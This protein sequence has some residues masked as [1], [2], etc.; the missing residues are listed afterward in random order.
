ML[1]GGEWD[2]DRPPLPWGGFSSLGGGGAGAAGL[3]RTQPPAE[4]FCLP[5]PGPRSGRA[6]REPL[7]S[8]RCW[9]YL[10]A[11][12]GLG[13]NLAT[14]N[15]P[16]GRVLGTRCT[17]RR[18]KK[19]AKGRRGAGRA[20]ARHLLPTRAPLPRVPLSPSLPKR[21]GSSFP[22]R[23]PPSPAGGCGCRIPTIRAHPRGSRC[24]MG[25][26]SSHVH[27]GGGEAP[28]SGL[29]EHGGL[30]FGPPQPHLWLG[31]TLPPRVPGVLGRAPAH[32]LQHAA[33]VSGVSGQGCP[34]ARQRGQGLRWELKA[35]WGDKG[36][37]RSCSALSDPS[38]HYL[39][40]TG[41]LAG[42]GVG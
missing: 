20:A 34:R 21:S 15:T 31:Q 28:G 29:C 12:L 36:L 25:A 8:P 26:L 42:H 40:R 35:Q 33:G 37:M 9:P 11:Y 19:R 4:T 32:A 30:R 17:V 39:I 27:Q 23:H 6:A 24:P 7:A 22:A 13:L 41:C 16:R 1:G 38:A 5:D 18:R 10:E 3:T 2:Q 14:V